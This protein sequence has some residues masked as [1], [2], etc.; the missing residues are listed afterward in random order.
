M[1]YNNIC[2]WRFFKQWQTFL[3]K[4]KIKKILNELVDMKYNKSLMKR[5]LR[6]LQQNADANRNIRQLC[7]VIRP[8]QVLSYN[9][10]V[11]HSQSLTKLSQYTCQLIWSVCNQRKKLL[12]QYF[13][14]WKDKSLRKIKL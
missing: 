6:R 13:T 2:I 7:A 5:T 8:M 3:I 4:R 1:H 11:D 14:I 9:A 12:R 10:I